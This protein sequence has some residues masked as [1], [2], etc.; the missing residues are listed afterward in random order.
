MNN[1]TVV[2]RGLGPDELVVVEGYHK[3]TPGT[4]VKPVS[5]EAKKEE[6]VQ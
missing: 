5:E 1:T 4:L 2:E 3:L 6:D